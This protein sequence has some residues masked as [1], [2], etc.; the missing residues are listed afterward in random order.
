VRAAV[1]R[2]RRKLEADPAKPKLLHTVP[3]VGIILKP[4]C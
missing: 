4:E 2:L 3:G 1:Y